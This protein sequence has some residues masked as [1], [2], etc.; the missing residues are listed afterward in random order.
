[1]K[2]MHGFNR[3]QKPLELICPGGRIVISRQPHGTILVEIKA[4]AG[5]VVVDPKSQEWAAAL[6]LTHGEEGRS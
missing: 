2:L 5:T 1:M 3:R 6:R 4:D